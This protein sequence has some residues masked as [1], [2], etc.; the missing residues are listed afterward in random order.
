M[1]ASYKHLTE[2]DRVF[3]QIMLEKGYPKPKIAR[4]LKV[5]RST[6]YRE[7]NRNSLI[8]MWTS[9]VPCYLPLAAQKKYFKRRK[10]PTKL[11]RDNQ[12]CSYVHDKL[13]RGWSPWQIEGRLK[14]ENS[15][16][17]IIS[18]ETIYCY[19]YPLCQDSCRLYS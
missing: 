10:R 3:L 18:H 17:V 6:I 12:L 19:I 7:L 13:V 11:E 1:G 4:I 5:H 14:Y 15:G 9:K 8:T 2:Q 16:R